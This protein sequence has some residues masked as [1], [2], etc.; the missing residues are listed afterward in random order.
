[1]SKRFDIVALGDMLDAAREVNEIL[2]GVDRAAL[3]PGEP[4]NCR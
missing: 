1:M 2:L 3:T 4:T